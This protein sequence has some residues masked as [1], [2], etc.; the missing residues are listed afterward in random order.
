MNT[1][2]ANSICLS[3]QKWRSAIGKSF[4]RF[5]PGAGA[6]IYYLQLSQLNYIR[7]IQFT[8]K[9]KIE[10]KGKGMWCERRRIKNKNWK[11]QKVNAAAADGA[12]QNLSAIHES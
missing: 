8:G 3:Q 6:I 4:R 5:F 10:A 1:F 2:V 7:L 9:R 12:L 11:D